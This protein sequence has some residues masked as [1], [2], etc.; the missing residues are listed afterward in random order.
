MNDAPLL[1]IAMSLIAGIITGD[2]AGARVPALAWLCVAAALLVVAMA[3]NGGR[4]HG[5]EGRRQTD[6][7]RRRGRWQSILLLG[8]V[9][10]MGAALVSHQEVSRTITMP[11]DAIPWRGVVMSEPQVRGK[12]VR[13]DIL[14]TEGP[15]RQPVKVKA[16][17]LRDTL[18]GRWQRLHVGNGIEALS[19]M[20][21]M[22]N[23]RQSNF[24][25]VRWQQVHGY[26]FNT[27]IY[28]RNWQKARVSLRQ[29]PLVDRLR[30]RMLTVRHQLL[31][32]Y[33][34]LGLDEQ[35]Y[36]VVAAMTLGEKGALSQALKDDYSMSG[37][38]HVLALSGLHLSVIYAL[39]TFCFMSGRRRRLWVSQTLIVVAIWMYVL[40]VGLMPSVVRSATILTLYS[41]C[42]VLGRQGVTLSNL[43][44]AAI[45]ML[46]VNPQTLWDVGF[47]M[48]FMAVAAIVVGYPL[49]DGCC[50]GTATR[51][52]ANSINDFASSLGGNTS[53]VYGKAKGLI[54]KAES[55]IKKT[56]QRLLR[57][58]WGMVVM[59]VSAQLGTAPLVAYYFGRFSCYFLLTNFIVIPAATV[60]LYGAVAMVAATPVMTLQLLIA[61]ALATVA[62]WL[63]GAVGWI[64]QLPGASIENIHMTLPQVWLL[65]VLIA[66]AL[67]V[68]AISRRGRVHALPLTDPAPDG[69]P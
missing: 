9:M 26:S 25:Y 68:L 11:Q 46:V 32:H 27:F 37:G 38:S 31:A 3:F 57:W 24:D 69:T 53:S 65:Y 52:T 50:R 30:L 22:R 40:L 19:R 23:F 44:C 36:A 48:S 58:T 1:P 4:R 41:L 7:G 49:I 66:C 54:D 34:L 62:G 12:V 45:V 42:L 16:A 5:I 63:N 18:T 51:L 28:Y 43:A 15:W 59:A 61:E 67:A 56:G 33:Q 64:A 13:C 29:L 21:P 6:D 35:Q 47:Q 60:I 2:A 17:I 14:I 55:L 10:A 39:L 20:E 8:C